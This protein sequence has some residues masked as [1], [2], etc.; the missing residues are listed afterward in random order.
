MSLD[1]VN[2]HSITRDIMPN[3]HPPT[4]RPVPC[5]PSSSSLPIRSKARLAP[6]QVAQAIATG[7]RRARGRMP[8]IRICPMADGGEG[9]L[10]A[11]LAA[12]R[13]AP[14]DQRARRGGDTARAATGLLADGSA[15]VETAE[16]VGITDPDGMAVPVEANAARAAWAKR[17]ARC[18][19]SACGVLRRARRQQHE[20]RRRRACWPASA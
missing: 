6:E 2:A 19:I 3:A 20:R 8:T 1:F 14:R 10:D 13:R 7:I 17:S 11:M 12:R 9:T 18:S 15:I 5:R 4:I 16:V